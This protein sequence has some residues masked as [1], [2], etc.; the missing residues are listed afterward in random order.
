[1]AKRVVKWT[2]TADIQFIGV[3]EYWVKRNK[4]TAYSKKL[5]KLVSEKTNQMSKIHLLQKRR[6]FKILELLP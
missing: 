5:Q 6:N 3:L 1:M 4:S 2:R